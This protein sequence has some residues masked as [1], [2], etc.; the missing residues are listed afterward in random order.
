M[1]EVYLVCVCV[2]LCLSLSVYLSLLYGTASS[3]TAR[4]CMSVQPKIPRSRSSAQY[5]KNLNIAFSL[6]MFRMASLTYF[7]S[8]Q[9]FHSVLSRRRLLRLPHGLTCLMF[10]SSTTQNTMLDARQQAII[11]LASSSKFPYTP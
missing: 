6:N 3:T 1:C 2:S 8:V 10:Y 11:F 9:P 7:G 4:N 5:E